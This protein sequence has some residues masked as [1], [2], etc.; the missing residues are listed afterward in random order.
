MNDPNRDPVNQ[1]NKICISSPHFNTKESMPD[2][3][4]LLEILNEMSRTNQKISE[5]RNHLTVS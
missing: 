1:I 4:I 2:T 5:N 3:R